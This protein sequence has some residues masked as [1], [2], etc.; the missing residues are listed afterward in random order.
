MKLLVA[1]DNTASAIKGL[2]YALSNF[3]DAEFVIVYVERVPYVDGAYGVATLPY[4]AHVDKE[5]QG[6]AKSICAERDV[7]PEMKAELGSPADLI[8]KVAEDIKADIVVLGAHNK[9]AIERLLL[10]SV[11]EAVA[12]KAHCSVLIVR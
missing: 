3:S 5:W 7:T 8:V 4:D 2:R 10:G 1:F 11:S 6:A 12:R 9:G